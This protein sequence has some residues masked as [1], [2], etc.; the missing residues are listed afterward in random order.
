MIKPRMLALL[1]AGATALEFRRGT[2]V[3]GAGTKIVAPFLAAETP[4]PLLQSK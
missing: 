3:A 1:A 4:Q 2:L